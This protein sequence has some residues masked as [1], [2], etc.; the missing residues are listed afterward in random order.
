MQNRLRRNTKK[1]I[2]HS[3]ITDHAVP[4]T[5]VIFPM[6]IDRGMLDRAVLFVLVIMQYQ[7]RV[8]LFSLP[9]LSLSSWLMLGIIKKSTY[10]VSG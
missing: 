10:T 2:K 8:N 6:L 5:F 4:L 3:G 7:L 1:I 9:Y